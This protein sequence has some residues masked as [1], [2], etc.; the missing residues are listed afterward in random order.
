MEFTVKL[1]RFEGPYTKLL[2]LIEAKK[3]S[4]TEIS[5]VSVADD[6]INYI[7]AIENESLNVFD[8]SQFIVVASTL[9]LMKAKSLLP[10]ISYTEDEEKEIHTLEEKL[11]LFSILKRASKNVAGIFMKT[12]MYG[13]ERIKYKGKPVFVPDNHITVNNLKSIAILTIAS[14]KPREQL[15]EIV[16]KQK[17]RIEEVIENLMKR[18]EEAKDSSFLKIIHGVTHSFED[19]KKMLIVNFLALLELIRTGQVDANQDEKT[20]DI[21][22]DINNK[23]L[24]AKTID[25]SLEELLKPT[26]TPTVT[27][28][29][30]VINDDPNN[31]IK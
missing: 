28:V 31:M 22:L 8:V 23:S 11:E 18:I 15:K 5:L 13:R 19:K 21:T 2:E 6:Y 17:V 4:I 20:N 14:F 12:P 1:D 30:P 24:E 10:N 9:I 26:E 25:D 7:K 27:P 29:I 3:L 16:V